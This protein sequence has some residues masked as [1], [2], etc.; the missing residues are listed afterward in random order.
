MTNR[1]RFTTKLLL[2]IPILILLTGCGNDGRVRVSGTVSVDGKPVENGKI[3]FHPVGGER[4]GSGPIR[5][6]GSYLISCLKMGDGLTPGEYKVTIVSDKNSGKP[7]PAVIGGAS[8]PTDDDGF[9][10]EDTTDSLRYDPTNVHVVPP[11]YNRLETTTLVR[12]IEAEAA[13]TTVDFDLPSEQ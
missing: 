6:D 9:L 5:K 4:S 13:E 2:T 12:V 1:R 3:V 7:D 11:I 8:K 10:P